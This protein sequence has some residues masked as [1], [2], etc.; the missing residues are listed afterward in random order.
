MKSEKSLSVVWQRRKMI[1]FLLL[2]DIDRT[3]EKMSAAL[4]T[5][6]NFKKREK[7]FAE[8]DEVERFFFIDLK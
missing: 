6:T 7:L 2:D 1:L 5:L 3:K 8:N 4:F